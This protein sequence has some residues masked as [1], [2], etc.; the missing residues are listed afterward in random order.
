MEIKLS[1]R[2]ITMKY[3]QLLELQLK[4]E[5]LVLQLE[6]IT[7]ML[8]LKVPE[9]QAKLELEHLMSERESNDRNIKVLE[10]HIRDKKIVTEDKK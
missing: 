8:E 4:N 9:R 5:I 3:R 1:E 10:R 6:Q 7:K 2:D